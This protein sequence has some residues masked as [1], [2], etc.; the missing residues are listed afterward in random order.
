M[1]AEFVV[2]L[3]VL[4]HGAAHGPARRQ[5]RQHRAAATRRITPACCR[6]AS[7]T[8]RP[9][10][11]CWA[12]ARPAS[13]ARLDE[14]P[15]RIDQGRHEEGTTRGGPG[16]ARAAMARPPA[17]PPDAR[18]AAP[19]PTVRGRV[20]R[21]MLMI[22]GTLRAAALERAR[23]LR[24]A[25][26][27]VAEIRRWWSAAFVYSGHHLSTSLSAPRSLV[28]GFALDR[29]RAAAQ[30]HRLGCPAPGALTH[31]LLLL[32]PAL[33]HSRRP[34]QGPGTAGV[35]FVGMPCTSCSRAP[36]HAS[37]SARQCC[38][39]MAAKIATESRSGWRPLAA[40]G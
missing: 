34:V 21:R 12:A 40:R 35:A 15:T 5:R 3:L 28:A 26:A 32:Q 39:G 2:Q 7:A 16:G 13:A 27:R 17:A 22:A 14:R 6:P 30:R 10:P 18:A 31:L 1:D 38:A 25:T 29:R 9:M 36:R 37:S 4:T 24:L 19:A 11:A 33:L 23:A 8:P 20:R